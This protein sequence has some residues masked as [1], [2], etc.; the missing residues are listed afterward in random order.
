MIQIFQGLFFKH[1]PKKFCA[2]SFNEVLVFHFLLC[3][4]KEN[5]NIPKIYRNF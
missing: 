3:M 2:L 5:E 1:L 4:I